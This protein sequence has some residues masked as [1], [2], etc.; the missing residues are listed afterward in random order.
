MEQFD[1]LRRD[2]DSS[3]TFDSMDD[4]NLRAREIILSGTARRAFDLSDEDPKLREEYGPGWG[5]QAL[6]AR[7]FVEAGVRFVSLNTGYRD[8][9]SNIKGALDNKMPR[10]V[11][12]VGVLIRDLADRGMLDDTLVITAGEF[13]RTPRMNGNQ[14]RDHWP[15]AQSILFA[16]GGFRHGQIIGSTNAHAEHPTSRAIGPNDFSAILYRSLGLQPDDSIKDLTG[17]PVHLLFGG[18][19]PPEML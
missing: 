10:H 14:G 4:M 7:R 15:Q 3:R 17:R 6:L 18:T 19:V 16:G 13:G 12:A 9:H 8:D 2:V 1:R 11:R 5:E